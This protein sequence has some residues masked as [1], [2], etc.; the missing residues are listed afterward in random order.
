MVW[1]N[2][3]FLMEINKKAATKMTKEK[4]MVYLGNQIMVSKW[5]TG[6]TPA[7]MDKANYIK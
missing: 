3:I 1:A 2:I 7:D 6:K 4:V 5:A